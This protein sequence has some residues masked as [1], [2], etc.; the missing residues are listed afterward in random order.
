MGI[1]T[2]ST[3]GTFHLPSRM[4]GYQMKSMYGTT[5]N[6]R[7]TT[8]ASIG[9]VRNYDPTEENAKTT[10]EWRCNFV[11]PFGISGRTWTNART[12]RTREGS[13]LDPK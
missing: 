12:H 2:I 4:D 7:W 5:K 10:D 11:N 13:E 6:T 3:V 9:T 8:T 1:C